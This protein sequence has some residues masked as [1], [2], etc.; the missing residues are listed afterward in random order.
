MDR[1]R[2]QVFIQRLFDFENWLEAELHDFGAIAAIILLIF[3]SAYYMWMIL[4]PALPE[5]ARKKD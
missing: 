5:K 1:G 3:S 2:A 4:R